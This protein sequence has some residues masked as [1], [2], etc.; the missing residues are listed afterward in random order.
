MGPSFTATVAEVL[1]ASDVE[2]STLHLEVTESV[3]LI[4]APRARAVLGELKKLG[5]ILALDD[6]G[7][8]YSSLGYLQR[9]PFD[10]VK[11][12]R[13]FIADMATD[14]ATRAIVTAVINLSHALDLYVVAEG[15]ETEAQLH[16]VIEMGADRAQGHYFS[17]ALLPEALNVKILRPAGRAPVRFPLSPVVPSVI[18]G[19][20]SAEGMS[21]CNP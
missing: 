4:D 9:F 1:E 20:S 12:D 6:F 8:G 10:V 7:T 5:V 19:T 15:V 11:I 14:F 13:G 2:P 21:T 16:Q 17:A 3:L 18:P